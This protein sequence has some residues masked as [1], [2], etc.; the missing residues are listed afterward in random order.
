MKKIL[1]KSIIAI[2][3][4]TVT[5][6]IA[7]LFISGSGRDAT[8]RKI[9]T[10][11]LSTITSN[12]KEIKTT[13]AASTAEDETLKRS[14]TINLIFN[15]NVESAQFRIITPGNGTVKVEILPPHEQ[16]T[17]AFSEWLK[18]N[19]YAHINIEE[20]SMVNVEK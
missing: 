9:D 2:A 18:V 4:L 10:S 11:D 5:T 6:F 14:E 19:G 17:Q 7:Y 15:G 20:L 1:P 3:L 12:G 16:N 8:L 13:G